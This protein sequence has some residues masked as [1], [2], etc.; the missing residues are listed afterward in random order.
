MEDRNRCLGT[1]KRVRV[2]T[3]YGS[4]CSAWDCRAFGFGRVVAPVAQGE[5]E[6]APGIHL[7]LTTGTLRTEANLQQR[8]A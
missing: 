4:S 2:R 5:I 8:S 3:T 7:N 1:A 6:I